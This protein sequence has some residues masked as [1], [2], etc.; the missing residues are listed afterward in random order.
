MICYTVTF[1]Y[2][3]AMVGVNWIGLQVGREGAALSGERNPF[4]ENEPDTF[5][6]TSRIR[7][8]TGGPDR[9][10]GELTE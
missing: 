7:A 3:V 5:P 4:P 2:N 6:E 10:P 1:C 8:I 9:C